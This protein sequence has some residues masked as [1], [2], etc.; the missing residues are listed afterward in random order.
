MVSTF[1]TIWRCNV[2]ISHPLETPISISSWCFQ[3]LV[4]PPLGVFMCI[5]EGMC[6]CGH[7]WVCVFKCTCS[8]VCTQMRVYE[9][10]CMGVYL[11]LL[12]SHELCHTYTFLP[13]P[14]LFTS[15]S[16]LDLWMTM[17][18]VCLGLQAQNTGSVQAMLSALPSALPRPELKY[19]F[20]PVHSFFRLLKPFTAV[21]LFLKLKE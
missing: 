21:W 9:C 3:S 14:L 2:G 18:L 1:K 20:M 6:E 19:H 17:E 13:G 12:M 5:Q 16:T 11:S 8:S 10:V 4:S 15:Q 7:E